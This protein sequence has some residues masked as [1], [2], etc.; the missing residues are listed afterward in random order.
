MPLKHYILYLKHVN[1]QR[2]FYQSCR[3]GVAPRRT[4]FGKQVGRRRRDALVFASRLG[5]RGRGALV[6]AC[7]W[8]ATGRWWYSK[9]C[10][11]ETYSFQPSFLLSL[12]A[13]L[14][15]F[16]SFS[17]SYIYFDNLM[18]ILLEKFILQVYPTQ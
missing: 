18:P 16:L 15:L 5:R 3:W 9:C 7:R 17:P 6:V 10:V 14:F 13:S 8:S 2:K 12:P 11:L 1:T 4:S